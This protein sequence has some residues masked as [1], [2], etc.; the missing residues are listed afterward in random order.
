MSKRLFVGQP[1]AGVGMIAVKQRLGDIF[2]PTVRE[3]IAHDTLYLLRESPIFGLGFGS[4]GWH[5]FVMSH[6]S[7]SL[8]SMHRLEK[9]LWGSPHSL[10]LSHLVNGGIVG[11]VLW[12]SLIGWICCLIVADIRFKKSL[13][14][15][16]VLLCVIS[17]HLYGL[18]ESMC[19]T[20]VIWFI[21][22]L[23]IG[24]AA[25]INETVMPERPA[26]AMKS[27][28][29]LCGVMA[30]RSMLTRTMLISNIIRVFS[31]RLIPRSVGPG[32]WENRG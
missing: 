17:F 13:E 23:C 18:A 1:G 5:T 19:F 9:K 7:Q 26:G 16:P 2:R 12:L 24:Y 3:R 32:G 15:L 25:T 21:I 10:Y 30:C 6:I 31:N 29:V 22:F 28:A 11:L 4:Y 27:W 20:P 8:F 14:S